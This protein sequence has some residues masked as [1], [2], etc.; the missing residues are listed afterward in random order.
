VKHLF[1]DTNVVVDFLADRKPFS[2]SATKLFALS[3]AKELTLYISAI[4]YNNIYYLF[5]R[6]HSHTETIGLL[7]SL[8]TTTQI[9]EVGQTV[10]SQALYANFRDFED[11]IQYFCALG[12]PG[13]E[14]IV[15]RNTK[16]FRKSQLP[17][18][19]PVEALASF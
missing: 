1:L 3:V 10:I 12:I 7:K 13:L 4:S 19:T 8:M 5:Q 16:D 11:A 14:G 17:V 6:N 15:T 9:V 18:L 2:E